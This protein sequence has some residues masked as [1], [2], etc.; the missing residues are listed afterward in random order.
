MLSRTA[1]AILV[2]KYLLNNYFGITFAMGKLAAW[3]SIINSPLT[4]MKRLVFIAYYITADDIIGS[5]RY[6]DANGDVSE[7]TVINLRKVDFGGL[8]LNNVRASV[9]RNQK[10]PLLLG[11]SVLG[12]LGKIEIDNTSQTLKITSNKKP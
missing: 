7:G 12:R 5:A 10:A 1:Y 8:E 11:Q 9:V 4:D 6:V 3:Q 2:A